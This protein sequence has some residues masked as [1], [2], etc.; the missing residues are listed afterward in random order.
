MT[1]LTDT[2][3]CFFASAPG[4]WK[5][6]MWKSRW[7]IDWS[8][9]KE[10]ERKKKKKLSTQNANSQCSLYGKFL[11]YFQLIRKKVKLEFPLKIS[12]EFMERRTFWTPRKFTA[13]ILM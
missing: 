3:L 11:T 2:G 9:V 13:T 8:T 5:S 1:I 10:G 7:R 12:T 4:D 6:L